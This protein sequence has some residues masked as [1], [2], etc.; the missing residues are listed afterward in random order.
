MMRVSTDQAPGAVA[1]YSQATVHAGTVYCAGQ[2]GFMPD[3]D[4]GWE[5]APTFESQARYALE[6]LRSVLRAAGTDFDRVLKVGVFLTSM[7]QYT[8]FNAIYRAFLE[9]VWRDAL[10]DGAFEQRDEHG[11]VTGTLSLKELE[12]VIQPARAAVAVSELPMGA[13]VEVDCIAAR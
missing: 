10:G 3:G 6:N 1:D 9:T 8:A 5:L 7:E 11:Q 4:G 12:G 2:I 13:L